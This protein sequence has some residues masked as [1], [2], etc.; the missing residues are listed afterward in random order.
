M[1]NPISKASKNNV[2]GDI[3]Y[4]KEDGYFKIIKETSHCRGCA[5][6][7]DYIEGTEATMCKKYGNTV[8]CLRLACIFI[9][10][11]TRKIKKV[12][13]DKYKGILHK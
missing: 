2:I 7:Q 6:V 10:V 12:T 3:I 13:N 5:F 8:D 9:P 1:P 4:D 11:Y